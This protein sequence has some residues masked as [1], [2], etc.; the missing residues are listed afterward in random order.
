MFCTMFTMNCNV[1]YDSGTRA[2]TAMCYRFSRQ[3]TYHNSYSAWDCVHDFGYIVLHVCLTKKITI[4]LVWNFK[5]IGI[6]AF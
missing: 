2:A 5:I 4:N 1:S 3:S 6:P